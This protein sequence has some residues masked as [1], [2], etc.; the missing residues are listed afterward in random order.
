MAVL[1]STTRMFCGFESLADAQ[2][3]LAV[4]ETIYR[5]TPFSQDAQPGVRGK[6]P[7]QLAGY[8]ISH[9]P[10]ATL[11]SGRSIIWLCGII[12]PARDALGLGDERKKN[13][14]GRM[15]RETSGSASSIS[16]IGQADVSGSPQAPIARLGPVTSLVAGFSVGSC[17][18]LCEQRLA[19]KGRCALRVV[20]LFVSCGPKRRLAVQTPPRACRSPNSSIS[21]KA[22]GRQST[23]RGA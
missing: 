10:M 9:L 22:R 21:A 13:A 11:C 15:G 17:A 5:F 12:S 1:P 3:Y 19:P 2:R 7:L 4:F 16:G 8:D 23:T 6:A 18:L 20:S 14:C